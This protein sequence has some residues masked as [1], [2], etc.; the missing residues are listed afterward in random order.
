[1]DLSEKALSV[2]FSNFE[3]EFKTGAWQISWPSSPSAALMVQTQ[4][5]RH[6]YIADRGSEEH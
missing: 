6:I 3:G 2:F 1:M 5:S 4:I